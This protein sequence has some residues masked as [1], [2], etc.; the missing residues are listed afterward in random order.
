VHLLLLD[1]PTPLAQWVLPVAQPADQ[2]TPLPVGLWL[3]VA[4]SAEAPTPPAHAAVQQGT[5]YVVGHA[6]ALVP[7]GLPTALQTGHLLLHLPTPT[8]TAETYRLMQLCP[9]GAGW[10]LSRVA[11]PIRG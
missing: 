11:R 8:G 4:P 5:C 3:Q 7:A 10:L 2:P 1:G 9:D 6:P